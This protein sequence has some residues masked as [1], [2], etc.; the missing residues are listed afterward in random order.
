MDDLVIF[1]DTWQEH[2]CVLDT[3]LKRLA[4]AKLT[5]NL[6]KCKFGKATFTYLG[7]GKVRP[8]NAKVQAIVELT[9]ANNLPLTLPLPRAG[10]LLSKVLS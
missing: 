7:K 10:R 9:R 4:Q 5:L 8:V 6:V 1:S 3:V 2:A